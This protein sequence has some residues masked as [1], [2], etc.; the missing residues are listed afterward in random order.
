MAGFNIDGI[1]E[2]GNL[3][4]SDFFML[5]MEAEKSVV[6]GQ[7]TV[8]VPK[9]QLW[10]FK[11][12]DWKAFCDENQLED[13][14]NFHLLGNEE[15]S[16]FE[17]IDVNPAKDALCITINRKQVAWTYRHEKTKYWQEKVN[18]MY[19][20]EE[21]FYWFEGTYTGLVELRNYTLDEDEFFKND[22]SV[23]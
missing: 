18:L 14:Y 1:G 17:R 5:L 9:P 22:D 10:G 20:D 11:D 3:K 21:D 15:L 4:D 12:F 13:L 16:I 8:T 19:N 7:K 23:T 2:W 6:K